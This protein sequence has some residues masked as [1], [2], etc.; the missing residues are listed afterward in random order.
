MRY[1][2]RHDDPRWAEAK[3]RDG[4]GRPSARTDLDMGSKHGYVDDPVLP[5]KNSNYGSSIST[6]SVVKVNSYGD[7]SNLAGS[8]NRA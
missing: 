6:R 4:G 3:S 8:R 1:L 5:S 7:G 2:Q